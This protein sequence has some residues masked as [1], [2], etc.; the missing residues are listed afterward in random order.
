MIT[1]IADSGGTKTD[2]AIVSQG[3]AEFV[4]GQGLHPAYLSQDEIASEVRECIK[5]KPDR[6]FFYGAGCHG[7]KPVEKMEAI[8]TAVFPAADVVVKDDLTGVARAHLRKRTGVI[9]ALGTGSICGVYKNHEIT[10]RSAALGFAIGDEGSAVDLGRTVLKAFFRQ[11][12]DESSHQQ[13]AERLKEIDYSVWMDK[14]YGSSRPN[15]ELAAVAGMVFR[16]PMER[17]VQDLLCKTLERF[18]DTQLAQLQPAKD[19]PVVYTGTVAA[20]HRA[21][22]HEL[23]TK[24]GYEQVETKSDVIGGL[25]AYHTG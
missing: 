22:L 21:K 6:V 3:N 19:N 1:V 25:V 9:A 16:D 4:Q 23:M 2:W 10:H 12:L 15:R 7:K 5:E 24:K 13:V 14:I 8:L 20:S 11:N 17:G 18:M